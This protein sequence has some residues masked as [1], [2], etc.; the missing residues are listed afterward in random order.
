[1]TKTARRESFPEMAA[2]V[3]EMREIFDAKLTYVSLPG[4][5]WGERGE[6]GV[7]PVVFKRD[8]RRK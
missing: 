3:D 1:M 5:E 8:E 4:Y 6:V 2:F 7:Q